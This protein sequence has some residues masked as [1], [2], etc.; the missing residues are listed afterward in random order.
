MQNRTDAFRNYGGDT[1]QMLKTK[2]CLENLGVDVDIN[3]DLRPDLT[4]YNIVHLFNVTRIHETYMQCKNALEQHKPV[5]L[6]TIH[7]SKIDIENYEKKAL[8]GV[9]QTLKKVFSNENH[10]QLVKTL[11]YVLQSRKGFPAILKQL[12][13]G[14]KQQQEFVLNNS[15]V[16]LPNSQMELDTILKEF[17]VSQKSSVIVPNGVEIDDNIIN[18]DSSIFE[19]KYKIKDF[20]LCAG[21]IE[22]RK[23]QVSVMMALENSNIPVI[24]AGGLNNKHKWYI[25]KFNDYLKKNKNFIYIGNIDRTLLYSGFK[26]CK[27]SVLPSW[28]ETTGLV[29][30]EAGLMGTNV[31]ITNKGYTQE[32]FED[33]AWYCDPENIESIRDAIL[34][35][36]NSNRSKYDLKSKIVDQYTWEKAAEETLKAYNLCES[37]LYCTGANSNLL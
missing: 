1:T 26:A 20:I 28:F 7:H 4:N 8:K 25:T 13:I 30:L 27:V 32:Y 2:E 15:S 31:V 10:F 19:S 37:H 29:G 17:C 34:S 9:S 14:F 21:R 36:Y 18:T 12:Q 35:A 33:K 11:F 16:W 24:F 3:L 22:P 6:S 5:V 23:N